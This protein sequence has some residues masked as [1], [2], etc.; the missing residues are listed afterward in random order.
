MTLIK[1]DD[2]E[3]YLFELIRNSQKQKE[4][5]KEKEDFSAALEHLNEQLAYSHILTWI[6]KNGKTLEEIK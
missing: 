6:L 1:T 4:E 2:L 5:A 3:N